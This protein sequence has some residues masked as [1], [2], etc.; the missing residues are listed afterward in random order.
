MPSAVAQR[1]ITDAVADRRS[2][3]TLRRLYAQP[4]GG[5]LVAVESRSRLFPK[6]LA[7][8]IG[9][10]D[11]RCRTPYCDAPIRHRDHAKPHRRGGRTSAANGLG[12]CAGCN[13][14]KESPGWVVT[15][16]VNESGRH[17]A[18]FSTPTGAHYHSVAP[19]MPGTPRTEMGEI[20]VWL[21]NT[22]LPL[23]AA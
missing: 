1:L 21:N 14:T 8:F 18:E 11:Q 16:D 5:A 9:L 3:A 15:T 13:Y 6:G 4:A 20:E 2:R 19:P 22:L 23:V 17:T 10:R 7:D 12:L